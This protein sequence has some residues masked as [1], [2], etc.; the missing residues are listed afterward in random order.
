MPLLK[1]Y[2]GATGSTYNEY[3]LGYNGLELFWSKLFILYY[4]PVSLKDEKD[5][6]PFWFCMKDINSL[7]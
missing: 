6:F 1:T 5:T 3:T 4:V 2:I 7:A